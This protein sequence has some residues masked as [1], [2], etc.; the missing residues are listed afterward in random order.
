MLLFAELLGRG[1]FGD[2]RVLECG[3]ARAYDFSFVQY[4]SGELD[5]EIQRKLV[6]SGYAN[7]VPGNH[8]AYFR[9]ALGEFKDA[10]EG[11]LREFNENIKQKQANSID[12]L[13]CFNF[14][15]SAIA[16]DGWTSSESDD[17][18][19]EFQGQTHTWQPASGYAHRQRALAVVSL[20]VLVAKLIAEGAISPY[21]KPWPDSL[22]PVMG[23]DSN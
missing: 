21:A 3:L 16:E 14:N 18:V 12:L 22:P 9:Y 2:L 15:E 5:S 8:G 13:V 6:E 23:S 4:T 17:S 19:K 10:G 11:V 1:V 20:E 7:R